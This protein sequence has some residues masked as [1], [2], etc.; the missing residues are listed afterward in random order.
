MS[1]QVKIKTITNDSYVIFIVPNVDFMFHHFSLLL[2]VNFLW[3]HGRY[4]NLLRLLGYNR[5]GHLGV[6]E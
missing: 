4:G 3:F 5:K 1:S 6:S 2:W